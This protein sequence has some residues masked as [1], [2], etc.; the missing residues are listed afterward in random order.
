MRIFG[1][2]I[3]LVAVVCLSACNSGLDHKL[4]T[5]NGPSAYKASLEMAT[6]DMKPEEIDAFD[7]AVSEV[8]LKELNELYPNATP[9]KIIREQFTK[10]SEI[11]AKLIPDVEKKIPDFDKEVQSLNDGVKAVNATFAVEKDFFGDQPKVRV[12][13]VNT[14]GVTMT[15]LAWRVELFINGA[16]KPVAST[17]I[18]DNY[19][20]VSGMKS[21]YEYTR[22]FKLGFVSGDERFTTLEI[23]N[24]TKREL[25][26]TLEID[27]CVGLDGQSFGARNPHKA[28]ES[29]EAG[30]AKAKKFKEI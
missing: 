24:A 25:K 20:S 1:A 29:L 4:D 22:E 11:L 16:D 27:E 9:R 5:A 15:A 21:G 10:Y 6:K 3:S 18:A 7:A 26:L 28:L 17:T 23:Q 13:T 8:T 14:S 19:K 2:L 12:K 30:V